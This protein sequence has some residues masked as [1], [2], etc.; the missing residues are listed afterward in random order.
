MNESVAIAVQNDTIMGQQ[1]SMIES[2][3]DGSVLAPQALVADVAASIEHSQV[4]RGQL[5][6]VSTA[7]PTPTSVTMVPDVKH[8]VFD[9]VV[10]ERGS[11]GIPTFGTQTAVTNRPKIEIVGEVC[12]SCSA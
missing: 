5:S 11:T 10:E 4:E 8:S 7:R 1:I 6:L 3:R 9:K 12:E 2:L